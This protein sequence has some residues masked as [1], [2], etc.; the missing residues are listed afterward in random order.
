M[1]KE[2]NMAITKKGE[3][4]YGE[5]HNDL[6]E[7]LLNYSKKSDYEIEHF[8]DAIC[9]CGSNVFT[10]LMNEEEGVAARVCVSCDE[11][12]GIADSD[13]YIDEVESIDE[14]ECIC[15]S[16][17]FNITAGVSLYEES[18]DVR[19][20]YL[21]LFCPECNCLGCYGDWKNE[22]IGYKQLLEKI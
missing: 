6:R 5:T 22:F 2:T 20:F 4:Y 11:E 12:H 3:Y 9:T 21:G 7:V 1:L 14:M 10:V 16:N 19:W 13:E 8:K 17:K 15:G 18:N